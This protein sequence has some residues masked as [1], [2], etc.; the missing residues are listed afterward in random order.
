MKRNSPRLFKSGD[1]TGKHELE[2]KR[3][4]KWKCRLRSLTVR[5]R[6][7]AAGEV[8]FFFWLVCPFRR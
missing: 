4:V 5:F 2:I 7:A 3:I 1:G 6:T 8:I